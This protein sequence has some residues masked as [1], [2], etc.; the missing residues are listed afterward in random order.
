MHYGYG[1]YWRPSY[2]YYKV[3]EKQY[4]IMYYIPGMVMLLVGR[5]EKMGPEDLY[6]DDW[7]IDEM[8]SK[9]E[10]PEDM[11]TLLEVGHNVRIISS[12]VS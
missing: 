5:M 7:N 4:Y 2:R 3:I 12:P 10:T 1:S 6:N 9:I 8:E 11:R